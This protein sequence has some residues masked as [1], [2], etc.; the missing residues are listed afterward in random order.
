MSDS[1]HFKAQFSSIPTESGGISTP[2]YN[3]FFPLFNLGN[4]ELI[5]GELEIK[6]KEMVMPGDDFTALVTLLS[7]EDGLEEIIYPGADFEYFEKKKRVGSGLVVEVY[8]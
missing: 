6:G 2:I 4:D 3:G 5:G 8:F 7:V 1:P